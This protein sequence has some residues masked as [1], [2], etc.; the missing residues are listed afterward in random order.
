MLS[1]RN[2]HEHLDALLL[3]MMFDAVI[4]LLLEHPLCVCA[5]ASCFPQLSLTHRHL[6]VC[7]A[8]SL[9]L[10]ADKD[11]GENWFV[12]DYFTQG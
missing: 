5:Y 12:L 4:V 10:A 3:L 9:L 2:L 6:G 8:E 7:V 11:R 1:E